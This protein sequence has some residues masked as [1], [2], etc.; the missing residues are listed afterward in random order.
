MKRKTHLGIGFSKE[1]LESI[2]EAT[3][4][5]CFKID[6]VS[7]IDNELLKI[8]TNKHFKVLLSND[9]FNNLYSWIGKRKELAKNNSLMGVKILN[10][11]FMSLLEYKRMLSADPSSNKIKKMQRDSYN[12]L[13][14]MED[15]APYPIDLALAAEYT[16]A[17]L[18]FISEYKLSK[19]PRKDYTTEE[20]I[21][22]DY[23]VSFLKRNN[24]PVMT[25][26]VY[27]ILLFVGAKNIIN[28][29]RNL[30]TLIRGS[31]SAVRERKKRLQDWQSFKEDVEKHLF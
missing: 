30:I 26:L 17:G 15:S 2:I 31:E 11:M 1:L 4:Y 8:Q 13:K 14:I 22:L 25:E 19:F 18:S 3:D 28:N 20:R 21:F 5:R 9:D 12:L 23:L 24:V 16:M 6:T 27:K 29:R 10:S 7:T